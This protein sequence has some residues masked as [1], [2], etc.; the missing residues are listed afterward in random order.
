MRN[1]RPVRC[2][3]IPFP[4]ILTLPGKTLWLCEEGASGVV[5]WN[6]EMEDKLDMRVIKRSIFEKTYEKV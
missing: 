6:G 1:P 5:T 2:F 4:F 3:D